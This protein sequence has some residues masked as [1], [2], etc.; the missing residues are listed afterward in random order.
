MTEST[1]LRAS[2]ASVEDSSFPA[3]TTTMLDGTVR[4]VYRKDSGFTVMQIEIKGA[5]E[6]SEYSV[7]TTVGQTP[8]LPGV[9]HRYTFTGQ[10]T[11]HPKYGKQFHIES[12]TKPLPTTSAGIEVYLASGRFPG[13]GPVLAKRIVQKF[14][15]VTLDVMRHQPQRLLEVSG[16]GPAAL[17][18]M[19]SEAMGQ[20]GVVSTV[21]DLCRLGLTQ[22]QAARTLQVCGTDAY[23]MI[24]DNPY[25]LI[26]VWGM[27]FRKA[28]AVAKRLN[29]PRDDSRRLHSAIKCILDYQASHGR[30]CIPIAGLLS[31]LADLCGM[32][33]TALEHRVDGWIQCNWI[34]RDEDYVLAPFMVDVQRQIERTL[35]HVIRRP[36]LR[37]TDVS[38]KDSSQRLTR[39]QC[40]AVKRALAYP[41]SLIV[42][43]EGV[44]LPICL[45]A[46]VDEV[47]HQRLKMCVASPTS[48]FA[49][50]LDDD[51]QSRAM[52]WDDFPEHQRNG[53]DGP[54]KEVD[55]LIVV[56]AEQLDLV[57]A[58][59]LLK[60]VDQERIRIVLVGD[61]MEV[62]LSAPGHVFR[63]CVQVGMFPVTRITQVV[64]SQ[65]DSGR[66]SLVRQIHEGGMPKWVGGL[67]G[68]DC[69]LHMVE[70]FEEGEALSNLVDRL[71]FAPKEIQVVAVGP[72]GP[73]GTI[74]LNRW[75]QERWN[76]Q[77]SP[78]LM[79]FRIGDPVRS[80]RRN[81]EKAVHVMEE[82]EVRMI[83]PQSASMRV[84][85]SGREV[86]Y[87]EWECDEL[88]L[89]YALT[90]R[91]AQVVRKPC[92]VVILPPQPSDWL[93]RERLL[94][95]LRVGTQFL[96]LVGTPRTCTVTVRNTLE[97]E[98]ILWFVRH[99]EASDEHT[100]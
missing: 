94:T 32:D 28:D 5:E 43:G 34:V 42:G 85:F 22:A 11:T 63:A 12:L 97:E 83:D 59:R 25:R 17:T 9:G 30:V 89:S 73:L 3:S 2:A 53:Q 49:S 26:E 55:V 57:H 45:Q 13:V 75:F 36:A 78:Q 54:L 64:N 86:T 27:G 48:A 56:N 62:P 77:E 88:T 92:V 33:V 38:L 52:P 60:S 70:S 93:T 46:I 66:V 16:V 99:K 21:S 19:M 14:G 71:S 47:K 61:D 79:G 6:G 96:V 81:P 24:R 100:R 91:Q 7:I 58:A 98:M 44:G 95:A 23:A 51:D 15:D 31:Q 74:A 84:I 40:L 90:I 87:H 37:E 82:G 39:E 8:E 35:G 67:F 69:L 29:I 10:W 20:L 18:K 41:C 76:A 4:K 50:F 1:P 65:K 80:A 68:K 72:K